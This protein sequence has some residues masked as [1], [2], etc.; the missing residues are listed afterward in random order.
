MFLP[1]T[2]PPLLIH[3]TFDVI[4]QLNPPSP[5]QGTHP[6]GLSPRQAPAIIQLLSY[7]EFH[8]ERSTLYPAGTMAI[9]RDV[10]FHSLGLGQ[11]GIY[12]L[13]RTKPVNF[14]LQN[15]TC[16]F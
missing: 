14:L 15:A 11:H 2:R 1:P 10:I 9:K 6:F 3:S 4:G 5:T 16:A 12:L 13:S 8:G 7:T